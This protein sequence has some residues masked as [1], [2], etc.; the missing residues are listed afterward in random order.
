MSNR[1]LRR[2]ATLATF[3]SVTLFVGCS[4]S[5]NY[6]TMTLPSGKAIK[7]IEMDKIDFI[8]GA[9]AL[10]LK[11]QTDLKVSDKAALRAEANEIWTVFQKDADRRGL[12]AA[13]ISAHEI[14]HGLIFKSSNSHDFVYEK[15]SNG[16][17][18]SLDDMAS[19]R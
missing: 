9:P 18:H 2:L 15:D 16:V 1:P 3:L 4:S 8:Q 13:I 6:Q 14:P 7:V 10:T 5:P 12:L 11:Y 17:W 19:T